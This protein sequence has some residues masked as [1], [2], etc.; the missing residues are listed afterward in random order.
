[1]I[2]IPARDEAHSIAQVI[3]E[4]RRLYQAPIVV[5]DDG[6]QDDT[7]AIAAA[8]SMCSRSLSDLGSGMGSDGL[9]WQQ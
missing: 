1:M 8:G 6:G 2:L 9:H 4:A 5:I 7:V 3:T